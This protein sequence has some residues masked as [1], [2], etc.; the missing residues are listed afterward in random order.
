M[1]F[2]FSGFFF[3]KQ[4]TAYEMRISDWSSDVCSSDLQR[5]YR[6]EEVAGTIL[7]RLPDYVN[8]TVPQF[9]RTDVNFQRVPLVDTSH[10]FASREIPLSE[11]SLVVIHFNVHSR[12]PAAFEMLLREV[13]GAFQSHEQ[14]LAAPG[15][16]LEH[17]MRSEER[18]GGKEGGSTW[19]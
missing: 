5:G 15:P 17:A 13:P 3:F 8:F 2:I 11:E 19:S 10:P 12:V 4:K 14:P 7:R 18:G 6:P 16:Q 9:S 1:C